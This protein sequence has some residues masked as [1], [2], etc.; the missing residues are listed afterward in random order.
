MDHLDKHNI[1]S[2]FQHG[3]RNGASTETQLLR[4]VDLFAK[5]LEKRTQT[6]GI[7]LD[8]ARAF[9]VVPH[10]RLLLKMNYY[11]IRHCLPWIRNFLKMRKQCV[12]IDGVK[13]RFVE[14]LSRISQGTVLAG[15]L[16]LIFINDLPSSITN[17]FTG[18]F[19]YDTILANEIT[20]QSDATKLQ[21]DLDSVLEW[22]KL[23]GMKFNTVK[24]VFM[25]KTNKRKPI[26]TQYYL[27][28]EKLKQEDMVKYLGVVIDK[29]IT[30]EQ[31]IKEKCKSANTI[32]NM[33]KRNLHFAPKSVKCKAYFSCVLPIIE[34]ASNIWA[35][36]T[37]KMN[38][39]IE[40]VQHNSARFITNTHYK[41][42]RE[43]IIRDRFADLD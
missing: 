9:D 17:S 35:P 37:D 26:S 21:N 29:K 38:N 15:L 10:E 4:V 30:F 8:F 7:F 22:T 28:N 39:E 6:D 42:V 43:P 5:S 34:Y 14:V 16:F 11:G 18:I 20:D 40:M 32:L 2:N 33:L 25:T 23:W 24:C 27:G 19:C 1:L 41:L 12:I 3:Y 13:S 31:H 36:T